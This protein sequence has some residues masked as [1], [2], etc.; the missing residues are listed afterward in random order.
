MTALIQE[1][2]RKEDRDFYRMVQSLE[3]ENV[4]AVFVE[5]VNEHVAKLMSDFEAQQQSQKQ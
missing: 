5:G 1:Y 3:I 2:L 4:D